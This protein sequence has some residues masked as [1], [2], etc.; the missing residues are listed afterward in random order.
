MEFPASK[1]SMKI[2]VVTCGYWPVSKTAGLQSYYCPVMFFLHLLSQK[3][4]L[5][6]CVCERV[7][8]CVCARVSRGVCVG[9]VY[10]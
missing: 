1:Y 5:Y 4:A 10:S 3:F 7:G 9:G 2:K 8:R 6:R